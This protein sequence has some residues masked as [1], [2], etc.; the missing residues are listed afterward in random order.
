MSTHNGTKP[1]KREGVKRIIFA[2]FHSLDGIGS[3]LKHEAAFRQEMALASVLIPVAI[4]MPVDLVLKLL[5]I[6]SVLFV[7]IVELLN[8]GIEWAIDYIS[9]QKHPYAKRS[10]D[11][12]SGAVFLSLIFCGVTWSLTI[13]ENWQPIISALGIS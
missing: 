1:L 9:L 13:V 8:S 12:A 4:I 5:L 10:K 11:M 3:T 7:L 2:T 6:F